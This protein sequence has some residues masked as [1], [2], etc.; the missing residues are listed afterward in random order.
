MV[1]YAIVDSIPSGDVVYTIGVGSNEHTATI[2]PSNTYMIST[3]SN[4]INVLANNDEIYVTGLST[5]QFTTLINALINHQE[6]LEISLYVKDCPDT[7]ISFDG[8]NSKLS[9]LLFDGGAIES[10]S[11]SGSTSFL[12]IDNNNTTLTSVSF[13][14]NKLDLSACSN[15][16]LTTSTQVWVIL[17]LTG[18]SNISLGTINLS[19]NVQ[20]IDLTDINSVQSLI[21]SN[22]SD[23][24]II[25]SALG[26]RSIDILKCTEC[27][28]PE[29]DL[30]VTNTLDLNIIDSTCDGITLPQDMNTLVIENLT[31]EISINSTKNL[32]VKGCNISCA[33]VNLI[34]NNSSAVSINNSGTIG[35]VN[36][37]N[38][39]DINISLEKCGTLNINNCTN[40]KCNSEFFTI[41]TDSLTIKNTTFNKLSIDFESNN[42]DISGVSMVGQNGTLNIRNYSGT[43][44]DLQINDSISFQS[45]SIWSCPNI[46][47]SDIKSDTIR[48]I[49]LPI[50]E[51]PSTWVNTSIY[52]Y[53]CH[54]I[55]SISGTYDI[56]FAANCSSLKAIDVSNIA[57]YQFI[58]NQSLDTII[59]DGIT[60]GNSGELIDNLITNPVDAYSKL[61]RFNAFR[62]LEIYSAPNIIDGKLIYDNQYNI[63]VNND[64]EVENSISSGVKNENMVYTGL[65]TVG[66]DVTS[67]YSGGLGPYFIWMDF[68]NINNSP[69]KESSDVCGYNMNADVKNELINIADRANSVYPQ[70]IITDISSSSFNNKYTLV[71]STSELKPIPSDI[72]NIFNI[73]LII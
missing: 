14:G 2:S 72:P 17:K 38:L 22:I 35:V 7:S 19:S 64:T 45:C 73:N 39:S 10:I 68:T 65:C 48:L 61:L 36:A 29:I 25:Q 3:V 13:N 33:T 30:S 34:S 54:N 66:Q 23:K 6:S 41:A 15:V 43:T 46:N 51:L 50:T 26:A 59:K 24:N 53:S 57:I 37:N 52:L 32:N 12:L 56:L 21:C 62:N 49:D 44:E 16:E 63:T 58:W 5:G 70:I 42:I 55:E 47:L 11:I 60:Y 9:T 18:C 31:N 1:N 4:L 67:N 69:F 28:I 20:A 71:L 40:V 27:N 8:S